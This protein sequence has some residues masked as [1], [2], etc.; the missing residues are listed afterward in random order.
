RKVGEQSPIQVPRSRGVV[1]RESGRAEQVGR[2]VQRVITPEQCRVGVER[3]GRIGPALRTDVLL[4]ARR[5]ARDLQAEYD[6]GHR[7]NEALRLQS[8]GHAVE[9]NA[10]ATVESTGV[11]DGRTAPGKRTQ[12][13]LPRGSL[14]D[15]QI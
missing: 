7:P 14:S 3:I 4:E 9:R 6:D 2:L 5:R 13:V 12:K 8:D 1:G 11:S 10:T 15:T